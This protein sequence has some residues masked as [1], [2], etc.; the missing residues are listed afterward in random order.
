MID[1]LRADGVAEEL[2]DALE[3]PAGLDIGARTP[4]EVALSIAARIVEV[5][6]SGSE[7]AADGAHRSRRSIR[8]AA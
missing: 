6:R 4:A 1:E 7:P 2:L 8:S 3:T 5:R